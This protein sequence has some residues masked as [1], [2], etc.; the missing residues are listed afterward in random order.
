MSKKFAVIAIAVFTMVLMAQ[1]GMARDLSEIF[2]ECGLGASIFKDNGD[3]AAISNIVWD[4]GTTAT[5]S[6]T[7]TP[8]SCKGGDERMAIFIN[9]ATTATPSAGFPEP[10]KW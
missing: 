8:D 9:Q 2:K 3:A 4:S 6:A 1:P 5:S 10:E 7:T